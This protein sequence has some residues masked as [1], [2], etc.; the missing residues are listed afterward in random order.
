[1]RLEQRIGRVDRL[2]QTKAVHVINLFARGTAEAG[3]L[4][5]LL[6]RLERAHR[7]IGHVNDPLG[8]INE[9][10]LTN[11]LLAVA[12][13][14]PDE[15]GSSAAACS[16]HTRWHP[17][18]RDEA[19]AE[20]RRLESLRRL[21]GRDAA[22][23]HAPQPR[24][25]GAPRWGP[26]AGDPA[27]GAT[28]IT[29]IPAGRMRPSI[30]S[31]SLVWIVRV[32][33]VDGRGQLIE[34]VIVP[35]VASAAWF[36][37]VRKPRMLRALVQTLLEAVQPSF[38]ARALAVARQRLEDIADRHKEA[39]GAAR[40]REVYLMH[41]MEAE[42]LGGGLFQAG[43]FDRRAARGH[44]AALNE[45]SRLL[46]DAVVRVRQLEAAGEAAGAADPELMLVLQ[47][48]SKRTGFGVWEPIPNPD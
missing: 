35:L 9:D 22:A 38:F 4:V 39:V 31:S 21:V 29:T 45:Q 8:T 34:H 24:T 33:L 44:E 19:I 7:G 10:D 16:T 17:D 23:D 12:D 15:N 5:R 30:G 36:P 26:R 42:N 46:S 11:A 37:N 43:L 27:R 2:G 13:A 14:V 40:A 3:V 20:A 47:I 18:L 28:L 1:M 25:A 41:K 6:A 32:H 48:A